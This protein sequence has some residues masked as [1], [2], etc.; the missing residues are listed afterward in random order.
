MDLGR[1]LVLEVVGVDRVLGV[2]A[3]GA[4]MH[5]RVGSWNLVVL[6]ADI[7]LLL[8]LLR[9]L[10]GA[11]SLRSYELLLLVLRVGIKRA[12][13]VL[14]LRVVDGRR[15]VAHMLV[16]H[17]GWSVHTTVLREDGHHRVGTAWLLAEG[18]GSRGLLL[19][20]QALGRVA[21]QP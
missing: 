7:G 17:G 15:L 8:D 3:L 14:R 1:L 21:L 2:V 12:L 9:V 5:L 20:R 19:E 4:L 13:M 10:L 6:F 18:R 11:V 16:E